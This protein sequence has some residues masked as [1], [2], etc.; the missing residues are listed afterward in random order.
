MLSAKEVILFYETLLANSWMD[1]I[2]KIDLR[3]SRKHVLALSR[4]IELGLSADHLASD[5]LLQATVPLL[6][7][8]DGCA[9]A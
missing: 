9:A 8:I 5:S 1:E 7:S 4:V 2:V 6:D 3:L